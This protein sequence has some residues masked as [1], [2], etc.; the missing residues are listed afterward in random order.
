MAFIYEL[1][2]Y[3]LKMYLHTKNELSTS[4]LFRFSASRLNYVY[5]GNF[6]LNKQLHRKFA[7]VTHS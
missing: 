2:M 3:T 5:V 4:T 1:D 6:R 7:R